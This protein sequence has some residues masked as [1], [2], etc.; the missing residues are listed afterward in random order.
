MM[1]NPSKREKILYEKV[2]KW[3]VFDPKTDTFHLRS[4]APE[5]VKRAFE[6][7]KRLGW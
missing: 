6:E 4:D 3:R 1:I 7:L 2:K 5:D